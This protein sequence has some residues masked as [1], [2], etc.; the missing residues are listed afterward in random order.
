MNTIKNTYSTGV[1]IIGQPT[2]INHIIPVYEVNSIN[3]IRTILP[4]S[5]KFKKHSQDEK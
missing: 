4:G 3:R 5:F 2:Y 1:D